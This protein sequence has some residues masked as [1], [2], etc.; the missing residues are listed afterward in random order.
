MRRAVREAHFAGGGRMMRWT[1]RGLAAA[2]LAMTPAAA[3][4]Q[5]GPPVT[6]KGGEDRALS[7]QVDG[8]LDLQWR[9]VSAVALEAAGIDNKSGSLGMQADPELLGSPK[10]DLR[11]TASLP[12]RASALVELATPRIDGGAIVNTFGTGATG[13][14]TDDSGIELGVRQACVRIERLFGQGVDGTFGLQGMTF[15]LRGRGHPL[16]FGFRAGG[17]ESAWAESGGAAG[18]L[19][20]FRDEART[21]GLRADWRSAKVDFSMFHLSV[22]DTGSIRA[23]EYVTGADLMWDVD[24]DGK[25]VVEGALALLSGTGGA[26]AGLLAAGTGASATAGSGSEIWVFGGGLHADGVFGHVPAITLYAQAYFNAGTYGT[27]NGGVP[28]AAAGT[29]DAG[30]MMWDVGADYRFEGSWKPTLGLEVLTVSG[31]ELEAAGVNDD[32]Y[33]GFVGYEDNDDLVLLEDNEFGI[34]VDQNYQVIKFRGSIRGDL[35]PAAVKDGFALELVVGFATLVEEVVHKT[36]GSLNV[37]DLGTEIDI[38]ASQAL[39]KQVRVYTAVGWLTGAD[40]IEDSAAIRGG[41]TT[42][43]TWFLGTSVAF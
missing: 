43:F 33:E 16:L 31:N 39:S 4:A 27:G 26:A 3:P 14:A 38:K 17:A 18:P 25:T 23:N 6:G 20:T 12:E 11:I 21:G 34:D 35:F 15:D 40:V 19:G 32:E 2:G 8:S 24:A 36:T 22:A 28:G 30:G 1:L 37:D 29:I 13:G 41:A 10:L 9:Y 42:A 5:S 7:L